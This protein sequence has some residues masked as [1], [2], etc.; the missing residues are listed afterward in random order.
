MSRTRR[1][2]TTI[3]TGA[4]DAATVGL[5]LLLC[6]AA[7]GPPASAQELQLSFSGECPGFEIVT[8]SSATPGGQLAVLFGSTPG[9]V[10][11]PV[12]PCAG[13]EVGLADPQLL[14]S[15][16]ADP[17][18]DF[19]ISGV[20]PEEDC[21][22]LLQALDVATCRVTNIARAET[23][24]PAPVAATG[25]TD[26]YGTRDD[27]DL[28]LGVAWP[29]PRFT[30]N[31]DG[32][33]T[34]HLTNLVWLRD[35]NCAGAQFW[36][37]AVD[38]ANQLA[39]GDCGLADGSLPGDW[40]LSNISE[41]ASLIDW[42]RTHPPL[43]VGHPFVN[44]AS[45]DYWSST[46]RVP[47]PSLDFAW[48]VD[49]GG[50]RIFWKLKEDPF[51]PPP[52]KLPFWPVRAGI[53]DGTADAPAPVARTG[54]TIV[55]E[56]D[57]DGDRQAG[58]AWPRPRFTDNGDGTVTDHLTGLVWLRDAGCLDANWEEALAH[59]NTLAEG[60]CGLTDGSAPGDWRLP[61]ARELSSLIDRSQIHPALPPTHPFTGVS[62]GYWSS[63]SSSPDLPWNV[64]I[65][66]F[67][68]VQGT[69]PHVSSG[70]L[71][72][73][74]GPTEWLLLLEIL[75]AES[76][77]ELG[78]EHQVSSAGNFD[79]DG[80][81]DLI[82]GAPKEDVGL[83]AN[84]GVARVH[85]GIGGTQL[86]ALEGEAIGL[87]IGEAVAGGVD[88]DL[89]ELDDLLVVS[90]PSNSKIGTLLAVAA[91]D[92]STLYSIV[93]SGAFHDD[94][95]VYVGDLDGDEVSDFVIGA[96]NADPSFTGAAAA[97]SGADGAVI[98]SWSGESVFDH[99]GNA[100]AP[101]GDLNGDGVPEVAIAVSSWD[102]QRGAVELFDGGSG[103]F[104]H[105]LSPSGTFEQ[106]GCS[107]ASADV[108][109]D[110]RPNLIVGAN[111]A[112]NY[113][114]KVYVYTSPAAPELPAILYE[115]TGEPNEFLGDLVAAPGDIDADG[116][117]DFAL[118]I[119]FAGPGSARIYSG[120]SGG[121][122]RT[123]TGETSDDRFGSA[124]AG[125]GDLNRDGFADFAIGAY[126]NDE[127]GTDAGKVYVYS[128]GR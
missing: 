80:T 44:V 76:G 115:Y 82:L 28:E 43:P 69:A 108:D 18:G 6:A 94:P 31:G 15:V 91:A 55:Y 116:Y 102:S 26:S 79:G 42:S 3:N 87:R 8:I 120:A 56:T 41:L 67:G 1:P 9:T 57:D 40:R 48:S 61:N 78:Q 110:G 126:G 54:Q 7:A 50:G 11:V 111:V 2:R 124:I 59:A 35:A 86:F 32:T 20:L 12:G 84:A 118:G 72:V 96:D 51:D 113:R 64:G 77:G 14:A 58:I 17:A 47:D 121:L 109:G 4:T 19:A 88:L 33:V 123:L 68:D 34:D 30:D 5:A 92:G 81:P 97:Y 112:E 73:R 99:F 117:E 74:G 107:L 70:V 127:G 13:T 46:T 95:V 103:D 71:P 27:G 65:G 24:V 45:M 90:V 52:P 119:A 128:G 75:G 122:L 98:H 37:D 25:Q 104:L 83:L 49:M 125:L 36:P 60:S 16:T 22:T 29:D 105:R 114:G 101:A 38:L 89:D 39:D 23:G 66:G 106:F 93:Y 100:V 10:N 63:T 53:A 85:S 21:G 62:G